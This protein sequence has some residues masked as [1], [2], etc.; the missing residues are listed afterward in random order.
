MSPIS[1]FLLTTMM[2]LTGLV[3]LS[4]CDEEPGPALRV[5]S[6]VWP[7]YE[8]AY[9]AR[10]LG[11]IDD[12]TFLLRQ[13]PS[14]TESIRAFRNGVVDIVALTLDEALL[15][16]QNG[17]D[18]RVILVADIS[19]GADVVMGHQ[20]FNGMADLRGQ[21]IGVESSALGAYVLTRALQ[22]N[23]LNLA[24]IQPVYL[25]VDESEQAF[26]DGRIDAV[27][28]FDPFR[29]R[30]MR[31][32]AIELFTSKEIPGEVVD[33]FVVR[34]DLLKA[35]PGAVGAF[36]TAWFRALEYLNK[37]PDQAAERIGDRLR[38]SAAEVLGSFEGLSFPGLADNH[39]LLSAEENSLAGPADILV[40][41]M[42]EAKLLTSRL[43]V[44]TL[45]E[46]SALPA[47]EEAKQ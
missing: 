32:G 18:I 34:N 8:P 6:N 42:T 16:V 1:R 28:T 43:S 15:L 4:G 17:H 36:T 22:K 38:L 2:A 19:E 44:S 30:L 23:G 10:D 20:R 41:I 33:V 47:E 3:V 40:N 24:D 37:H 11:F 25:T 5:G 14:A 27:V 9:L 13:F 12:R 46:A 26:L 39:R 45:F 31:Q 35:R 21:R 29:T 7:G